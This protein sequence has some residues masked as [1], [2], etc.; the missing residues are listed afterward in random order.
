[1]LDSSGPADDQTPD[2]DGR[3]SVLE[4]ASVRMPTPNID[5]DSLYNEKVV[6]DILGV[7]KAVLAQ[8]RRERKIRYARVGNQVVYLGYWLNEWIER[9][10]IPSLEDDAT[11]DVQDT[12]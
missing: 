7:N 6:V 8:A 11:G 9:I 12:A 2:D 10:A 1:M 5:P 4:A 3:F